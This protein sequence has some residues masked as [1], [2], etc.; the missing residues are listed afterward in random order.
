MIVDLKKKKQKKQKNK[1]KQNKK[2][3]N[4]KPQLLLLCLHHRSFLSES[5]F[6]KSDSKLIYGRKDSINKDSV[7]TGSIMLS[8]E[9]HLFFYL[10]AVSES[11]Q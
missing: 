6:W 7:F 4:Q 9:M 8:G 2:K 3:K 1:T 11:C 5:V 10:R